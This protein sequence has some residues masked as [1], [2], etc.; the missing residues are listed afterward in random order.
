MRGGRLGGQGLGDCD[1]DKALHREVG[2]VQGNHD[3]SRDRERVPRKPPDPQR[4]QRRHRNPCKG[5]GD[6]APHYP[7][8]RA[9]DDSPP[10]HTAELRGAVNGHILGP[11]ANG[12]DP[13]RVRADDRERPGAK[14]RQ[15]PGR[16]QRRLGCSA[17]CLRGKAC[18]AAHTVRDWQEVPTVQTMRTL[19]C[20][21]Q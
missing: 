5:P 10:V 13:R 17:E 20:L 11:L 15:N 3:V 18:D 4:D 6:D 1:E 16:N 9:P 8:G 12:R 14:P 2:D 19:T 7:P 21:G